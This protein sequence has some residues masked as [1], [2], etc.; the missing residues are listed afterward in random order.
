MPAVLPFEIWRTRLQ[1][2]CAR[3]GKLAQFYNLG[4]YVLKVLWHSGIE[5]SA[6]ALEADGKTTRIAAR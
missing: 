4:D 5:P 1:D 6:D 2:D 3:E